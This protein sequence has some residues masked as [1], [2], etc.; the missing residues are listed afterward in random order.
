VIGEDIMNFSD[1]VS[2]AYTTK[3]SYINSFVVDFVPGGSVLLKN[4]KW[5]PEE[6]RSM[7]LFVKSFTTPQYS[8]SP[9]ESYVADQWQIQNGRYE[10][11]KYTIGFKDHDGH[12]LYR[13]FLQSL[14]LHKKA[15]LA[16]CHWN[17]TISKAPEYVGD[18]QVKIIEFP[19]SMIES[20]SQMQFS[21]ETE[22]QIAEFNVSFKCT[23]PIINVNY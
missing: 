23:S 11:F 10:L 18:P 15:Y 22:G 6:L 4:A 20:V 2:K 21:N 3:W 19:M 16:E 14:T 9:I 8:T 13:K 5:N 1:A 12:Y 17:I 7:G